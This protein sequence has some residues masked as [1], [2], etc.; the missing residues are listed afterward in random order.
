[1]LDAL[2]V[3]ALLLLVLSVGGWWRE[4]RIRRR[5]EADAVPER[6]RFS[7]LLERLGIGHWIRDLDTGDMW[8]S[9]SF[10]Q[11]HGMADDLPA[12]RENILAILHPDDREGFS[13]RLDEAY[14]RGE[15]RTDYRTIA[16][17][18]SLRHHVV[19][20]AVAADPQTG[21]RMAYGFNLDITE[22]IQLQHALQ[23]R[24]AYLEAIVGHLPMGLSVFD[25]DLRLKVWNEAFI[26]VLDL[27][28]DLVREGVD[29]GELIRV[30]ARRG[31]Y[32]EGD[33]EQMVRQRRELALRFQPHRFE[34]TRPNGRTHL[35]IGEPIVHAGQVTG[36]VTTYTD[37]TEQKRERERLE[38]TSDM[39]RTLIEHI[40]AGVTMVDRHLE[41]VAWN[42]RVRE[43]LDLPAELFQAPRVTLESL[44]RFNVERGE[45][46]PCDDPQALVQTLLERARQF[47][48][49]AIERTRP[50]GRVLYIQGQ[51]LATGGFVTVYSDITEQKTHEA[52]IKRLART[53]P[54]TGLDHRG[55][56][57]IGLRQAL[58]QA[59]R[60]GGQL[61]VLF[62]DMDR[63]KAIND[64]LGHETGDAVLIE[65]ARRLRERLRHSDIVA[66]IG[67]DEFVVALT[68]I[69]AGL[70]AGQVATQLV[71][72]LSAPYPTDRGDVSLS[73]SIG[74]A[75]YPQDAR[76]ENELLRLADLAMYHAKN[77]GGAGF[78]FYAPAMNE[79]VVQRL[80][81]EQRLRESLKAD[82]LELHYQ[83]I[84]QLTPGLP[85]IGFEALL[86]WPVGEGRYIPPDQFIPMAEESELIELIGQWVCQA[87]A[88]QARQWRDQDIM[89]SRG[90]WRIAINLSA[91]QFDRTDLV[92][93]LASCF[94][95]Q[96]LDLS[97]VTF[98]ITE[99]A[100]MRDPQ[101]AEQQL[102]A[103][104]TRGAQCAVDDFGTGHSSLSY[105][106]QFAIDYLKI[107]KSFV[108]ALGPRPD[109]LAIVTAAIGLAHQLGHKTVAE[110][111][112]TLEQLAC[113]ERLGCDAVQGFLLSRPM[114]A[115]DVAAYVDRVARG[116]HQ[117]SARPCA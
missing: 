58:A 41:I 82:R 95:T 52:E 113:L 65:T 91:R 42:D 6:Q 33:I 106:R 104:R 78:R 25:G 80:D 56:F 64:S 74:I 68:G 72:A 70:D 28:P 59:E 37:I 92:E 81:F 39:L 54:L 101:R 11:Q 31:E 49:H 8:W 24:T 4:H 35:V 97:C 1:M 87:A 62:I 103:L 89:P 48:P 83:P 96:D 71:E 40:P 20:I 23:E 16:P 90:G 7:E 111:V 3:A 63:F 26:K 109:D 47:H 50:N 76:D 93:R 44:F 29:F 55:A 94:A 34:R 66:R 14:R 45:Y 15:G 105:L 46:G 21:H 19:R 17:D 2:S 67:G 115:A 110:G 114:P 61:A 51:P 116:D 43:L 10:R 117:P 98:E 32:G 60:L 22:H 5:A 108:H 9:S 18:G 99:G 13:A 75:L 53:D 88:R 57:T 77:D 79:A 69:E 30:P 102:Q 85:L 73:P 112:E 36:F 100:M 38:Q 107:D 86:R 27:P 12:R 84:H